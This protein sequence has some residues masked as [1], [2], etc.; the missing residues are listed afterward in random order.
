MNREQMLLA[1]KLKDRYKAL[2]KF[3]KHAAPSEAVAIS[4]EMADIRAQQ[5][6]LKPKRPRGR[7]RVRPIG[8][9]RNFAKGTEAQQIRARTLRSER[10]KLLKQLA[11]VQSAFDELAAHGGPSR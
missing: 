1:L 9:P 5:A 8:V 3:L 7:P 10:A 4:A 2:S 11:I 6:A